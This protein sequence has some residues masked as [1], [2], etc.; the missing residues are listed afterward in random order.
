MSMPLSDRPSAGRTL[1]HYEILG[2]IGEGGMG[3]V[4]KAVDKKLERVV[5]LKFLNQKLLDDDLGK[6]RFLS[7]ARAA[8]SLD[9]PNICPVYEIDEAEG[10]TFIAMAFIAGQTLNKKIAVE[11]LSVAAALDIAIQVAKGLQAAHE[12]GIVHRDVKPANLIVAEDGLVKIVDFGLALFPGRTRVTHAGIAVGTLAYMSPEQARGEAVDHRSD[13]WSLGVMLYEMLTGKLPFRSDNALSL[14]HSIMQTTPPPISRM[15]PEVPPGLDQVVSKA[16]ERR[17]EQRYQ[18]A[19]ELLTALGAHV[20]T[21]QAVP[22]SR[23]TSSPFARDSS[24]GGTA[25]VASIAVLPFVNMSSDQEAEYFSDGL[26]EELINALGHMDLLRVV[27]RTSVFEFKGKAQN[28]RT[29]G[30][31][32]NVNAVLEGSVRKSGEKLRITVQLVN[33]EDGYHLWSERYD[34]E[35]RDVFAVQEDIALAVGGALRVRLMEGQRPVA[36]ALQPH[37]IEAYDLYLKGRYC[38]NKQNEEGFRRAIQ[39]FESALRV[40]P[41]YAPAYCGLA[42]CYIYLG[43][44]SLAAP[45]EVWP[46]AK[47][48]ALK[49]LLLHDG[50]AEAHLSLGLVLIFDDWDQEAAGREFRRAVELNPGLANCHYGLSLYWTHVG[51]LDEAMAAIERARALDPLSLIF[52][53]AVA[54]LLYYQRQ[55]PQAEK[56]CRKV[57]DLDPNYVE[58]HLFLGWLFEQQA[59]FAEALGAFEKARSLAPESPF[60]LALLGAC[61]GRSERRAEAEQI[62]DR[63]RQLAKQ[64][65]VTPMCWVFLYTGLGET[66]LAFEWLDRAAETKTPLAG[67]V[68]ILPALDP[69]R[70]DPRFPALLSKVGQHISEMAMPPPGDTI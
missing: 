4:Y 37:N 33:V 44:W 20:S 9:H 10:H 61:Y 40:D 50:L 21:S 12:R 43:F 52:S 68:N 47:T 15:R 31:K 42:D 24:S 59:M 51:R 6:E 32:L 11:R 16:L 69:L 60:V 45:S 3:M 2:P 34:R 5:A 35:M 54:G 56:E 64:R 22:V 55:Y 19:K 36:S 70:S 66:D 17:P 67:Y 63:L 14:L 26:T 39:Y 62:V 1:S 48:A 30:E 27:S 8:A 7:E 13:I 25:A 29:I 46:K 18:S 41:T 57:L 65:F 53:T 58:A 38:W 23:P 28:I 49:A